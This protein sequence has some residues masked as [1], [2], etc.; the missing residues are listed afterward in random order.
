MMGSVAGNSRPFL[1]QCSI[2]PFP[3]ADVTDWQ[4]RHAVPERGPFPAAVLKPMTP[5][6]R[7][8]RG[9]WWVTPLLWKSAFAFPRFDVALLLRC[10]AFA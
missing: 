9:C 8:V 3:H 6:G 2:Y 1:L 4:R 10:K 7:R 5:D